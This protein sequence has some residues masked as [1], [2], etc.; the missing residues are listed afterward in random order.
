MQTRVTH[1][2]RIVRRHGPDVALAVFVGG[3]LGTLLRAG[4]DDRLP[5]GGGAWP[6]ATFAVNLAGTALLAVVVARVPLSSYRRPLVGT[7]FCGALTT[8]STLQIE[9]IR[10]ARNGHTLLAV[11]YLAATVAAGMAVMVVARRVARR[12]L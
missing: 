1:H 3:C 4:V 10:L 5:H 12:T 8:F 2:P 11:A 6:W 9:V 7:G